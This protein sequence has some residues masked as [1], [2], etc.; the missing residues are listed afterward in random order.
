MEKNIKVVDS[1]DEELFTSRC[2]KLL[3]AGY[4]LSS[5]SCGFVNSK[6]YDF[7]SAYHAIFVKNNSNDMPRGSSIR[8]LILED[9]E[10]IMHETNN[11]YMLEYP[12]FYFMSLKDIVFN[13]LED[14][15]LLEVYR[16]IIKSISIYKYTKD[17][18]E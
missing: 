6:E 16:D 18:N 4:I 8:N 17:E 3:D 15:K 9:I 14:D 10:E 1:S 12:S 7:C 13:N 5:S 2:N 11:F